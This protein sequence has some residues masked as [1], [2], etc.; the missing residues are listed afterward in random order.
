VNRRRLKLPALI[1]L[2]LAACASG[3]GRIR[4]IIVPA[5]EPVQLAEDVKAR[6]FVEVD[7]K[8]IQTKEPVTIPAGWWCLPDPG[9]R[10]A[11]QGA[12]LPRP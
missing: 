12:F 4:I 7:G 2:G 1:L 8:L 11:P 6:V 3:C 9:E 10:A 5:G